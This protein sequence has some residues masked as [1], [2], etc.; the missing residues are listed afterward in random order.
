VTGR[1]YLCGKCGARI[2]SIP[3]AADIQS[4]KGSIEET[5]AVKQKKSAT[6][7]LGAV[8]H[9]LAWVHPLLFAL[10]PVLY[11]YSRNLAEVSPSQTVSS[12]LVSVGFGI[13]I[14]FLFLLVVA[15]IQR[16]RKRSVTDIRH[17][18]WAFEK[19]AIITS[20]FLIL[21]FNYGDALAIWGGEWYGLAA[22][23]ILLFFTV[24]FFVV[25]TN[26]PL[27]NVRGFLAVVGAILIIL[28]TVN[29]ITHEVRFGGH[30]IVASDAVGNETSLGLGN[31]TLPD[32]Y[33]IIPD[34]Y[35]STSSL[36]ENFQFDNSEFVD[37]LTNKGFYVATDGHS[38]YSRTFASL[39][40][41]LNMKYINDLADQLGE[42][43]GYNYPMWQ[44]IKD[45]GVQ[46]LL[47]SKGYK[48]I[49][50]A[51]QWDGTRWNANADV[52]YN[53]YVQPE[54]PMLLFRKTLAY[55]FLQKLGIVEGDREM[56]MKNTLYLFDKLAE[57]PKMQ[58]PIFA[59]AHLR[60]PHDPYVFNSDGSYKSLQ[61]EQQNSYR[62][63]Y[64]E[65][66]EF[67]NSKLESFVDTLLTDSRVPPIIIIQADEGPFPFS[68]PWLGEKATK[69]GLE[70]KMGILNAY[71]LPGVAKEALYPSITPVNSFRLIFNLYFDAGFKLL[72]D[73]NYAYDEG[74]PYKFVYRFIDV[75]DK[76]RQK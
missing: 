53:L 75:T 42:N 4:Q 55:P 21:F 51:D 39:A 5:A 22:F 46:S 60:L 52:N 50:L 32:I 66:L 23:W 58:G 61:E 3:K 56:H 67:A 48:F 68:E 73:K 38:N 19:V 17:E 59:F 33:Y 14:F 57:I 13:L 41:S 70:I 24:A 1:R 6:S 16:L 7:T 10:F 31:E 72:D 76:L 2:T 29:I 15:G 11:L 37:Y 44:L 28:P 74:Y 63:N 20:V 30:V 65:Q 12:I 18:I 54:F 26:R 35:G 40:S 25:K 45:N 8:L 69:A 49:N 64:V 62:D 47:K 27:G 43:F 36:E 34:R 9:K 71:Y